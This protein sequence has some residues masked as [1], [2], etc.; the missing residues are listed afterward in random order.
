MQSHLTNC[1]SVKHF[2]QTFRIAFD[3]SQEKIEQILM[4]SHLRIKNRGHKKS[5]FLLDR[6]IKPLK[7]F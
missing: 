7:L 2:L 3:E 6:K 5:G 4:Q 1:H